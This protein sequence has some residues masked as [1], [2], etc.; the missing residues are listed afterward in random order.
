M[1]Q[2]EKR[3]KHGACS[4]TVFVNGIKKNGRDIEMKTVSLQ[5][6]YKDKDGNWQSTNSYGIND[7]PKLILAAS[8]AYDYLTSKESAE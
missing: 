7:L 5:R 3:F 8:K 2:P 6:T 1:A 4:A